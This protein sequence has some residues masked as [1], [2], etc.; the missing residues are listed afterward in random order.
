MAIEEFVYGQLDGA[1]VPGFLLSNANGV[2]ATVIAYGAR[3][4]ALSCPDR[5]GVFADVVLSPADI[6][7]QVGDRCYFG[8]ACGRY[9]NRIAKGRFALTGKEYQ[10][11]VNERGN[12][13][14][15][16]KSGFDRRLWSV[17]A[18]DPGTNSVRMTLIS[19]DGDEGYPGTLAAGIT[20]RLEESNVLDI[21]FD[22]TTDAATV[23][24]LVHHAYWNLAGEGRGDILGHRLWIDADFYTDVDEL[25]IPTGEILSVRGTPLDFTG[26]RPIGGDA[27]YS[28]DHNWCL[29]TPSKSPVD[30]VPNASAVL[31]DPVSGRA[32]AVETDQPGIQFYSAAHFDGQ[33]VGKSGANY[34]PNCAVALEPQIFPDS[35]NVRHFPE[36][37]LRPGERYRSMTRFHLLTL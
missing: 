28:Y 21:R 25:N 24:N 13:L 36:A 15:G 8:A 3:L 11:S 35:P 31:H 23:V 2:T 14:H 37:T 17:A 16:G 1:A 9:T 34:G 20:Y 19:P 22:A 4:V 5:N 29:R 7:G 27:P 12:H 32:L 26:M 10:L 6:D 30:S 18:V 33:A